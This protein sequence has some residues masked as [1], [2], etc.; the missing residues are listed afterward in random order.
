MRAAKETVLKL[1]LKFCYMIIVWLCISHF[2]PNYLFTFKTWATY[3]TKYSFYNI[4]IVQEMLNSII[5]GF[6]TSCF[7]IFFFMILLSYGNGG[8]FSPSVPYIKNQFFLLAVSYTYLHVKPIYL[9][10]FHR[11]LYIHV[12]YYCLLSWEIRQ[13]L[14]QFWKCYFSNIILMSMYNII[15]ACVLFLGTCWITCS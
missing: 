11:F 3:R 4:V 10:L 12:I 2:T 15:I 14:F 7:I 5:S 9:F 13:F 8:Y 1:N 6:I